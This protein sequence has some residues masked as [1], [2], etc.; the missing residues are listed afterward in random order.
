MFYLFW[1][2]CY[3]LLRNKICILVGIFKCTRCECTRIRIYSYLLKDRRVREDG[4]QGL[5]EERP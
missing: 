5:G 2:I 4:N 3:S 1:E